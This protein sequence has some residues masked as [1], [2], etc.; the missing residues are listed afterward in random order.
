MHP[1]ISHANSLQP[2]HIHLH[3]PA[4]TYTHVG[5][6]CGHTRPHPGV[7]THYLDV[8]FCRTLLLT[9]IY[10]CEGLHPCAHACCP[11]ALM[12]MLTHATFEHCTCVQPYLQAN[13]EHVPTFI[14]TYNC[15][16][17]R[18]HTQRHICFR[19]WGTPLLWQAFVRPWEAAGAVSGFF[20][21]EGC[22]P[23]PGAGDCSG[24]PVLLAYI[25]GG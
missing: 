22:H 7:A 5:P 17:A 20:L 3:V 2:P 19:L 11:H 9:Q 8:C 24:N 12:C 16:H 14:P 4:N 21:S 18:E 6:I 23:D 13:S 15:L 10:E 1:W 25:V